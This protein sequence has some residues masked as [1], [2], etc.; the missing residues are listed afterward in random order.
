MGRYRQWILQ[1]INDL[2]AGKNAIEM[3]SIHNKGKS[4]VVERFVRA[5]KNKV[6][7]YRQISLS[8]NV[9]IDKLADIV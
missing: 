1:Q 3:C 4:V 9:C 7:K 2:M 8:K 6:Y 5:L